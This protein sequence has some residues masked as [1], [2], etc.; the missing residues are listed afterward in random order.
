MIILI[1]GGARSGKSR[2]AERRA[3]QLSPH[4][5]YLA[6]ATIGDDEMADRVRRHQERRGIQWHTIEEP[7]HIGA[8]EVKGEVVLLDCLTLWATNVFFHCG[9][10]IDKALH[11]LQEEFDKLTAHRTTTFIVVTNEIGMGGVSS[12][13]LVRK[14]TDLQG[15]LNQYVAEQADEVVLMVSGIPMTIKKKEA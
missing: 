4:P 12:N 15:W 10:D 1:T 13:A 5:T 6:T 11:F 9:E 8:V 3:L 14:F 7:I 2:E